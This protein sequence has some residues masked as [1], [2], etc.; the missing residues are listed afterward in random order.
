[1]T[2]HQQ[3]EIEVELKEMEIEVNRI[4]LKARGTP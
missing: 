2:P 4:Q 3:E 1:L